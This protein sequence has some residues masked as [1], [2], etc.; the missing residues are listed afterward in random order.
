MSI[1]NALIPWTAGLAMALAGGPAWTSVALPPLYE[2]EQP[3][4]YGVEGDA[5][6]SSMDGGSQNADDFTLAGPT[7]ILTLTW[8]GTYDRTGY[9]EDDFT[10]RILADAGGEPGAVLREYNNLSTTDI[11]GGDTEQTIGTDESPVIVYFFSPSEPLDL[12]TGTYYLSVMNDIA[13]ATWF[14]VFGSGGNGA[15]WARAADG[16]TW[17][18]G[19][20]NL[21]FRVEGIPVPLPAAFWLFGSAVA[22]LAGFRYSRKG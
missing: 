6:L 5:V 11:F 20:S 14:W 21:A 22:G 12:A 15:S 2:Y 16:D 1:R 19:D 7:G 4:V 8:W 3:P 9:V 10:I 13:D 17:T 18:A